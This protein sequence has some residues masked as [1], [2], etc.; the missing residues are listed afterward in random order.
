MREREM[1]VVPCVSCVCVCMHRCIY[2]P[3]PE[4]TI[5]LISGT[6]LHVKLW[7]FPPARKPDYLVSAGLENSCLS[8]TSFPHTTV[9]SPQAVSSHTWLART[10]GSLFL[11]LI[12]APSSS[13]HPGPH[14]H[15]LSSWAFSSFPIC[16]SQKVWASFYIQKLHSM[17]KNKIQY[18]QLKISRLSGPHIKR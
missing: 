12:P 5:N 16:Y 17:K 11:S 7:F 15:W 4:L 9:R 10:M 2:V 1:Y 13:T 18:H 3:D 6:L 8:D 14:W